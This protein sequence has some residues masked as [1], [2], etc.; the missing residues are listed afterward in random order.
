MK[1]KWLMMQFSFWKGIANWLNQYALVCIGRLNQ[2]ND[3][4]SKII[5]SKEAEYDP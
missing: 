3:E 4:L 2:I 1:Y 5:A